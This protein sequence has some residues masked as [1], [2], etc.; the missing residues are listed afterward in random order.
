MKS[1]KDIYVTLLLP[2]QMMGKPICI[3]SAGQSYIGALKPKLCV[4]WLRN[5]HGCK[6]TYVCF[7]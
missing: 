7:C 2:I 5:K 1:H 6:N 4:N 3:E